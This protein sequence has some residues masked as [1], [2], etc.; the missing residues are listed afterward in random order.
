[1]DMPY[2]ALGLGM[3][4]SVRADVEPAWRDD[5]ARRSETFP[6]W[7]IVCYTYPGTAW[8][9]GATIDITWSDGSKYP[10]GELTGRMDG[11]DYPQ[12][13]ALLLGEKGVM[14]LPHGGGPQFFPGEKL[15]SLPRPKPEAWNHYHQ[16]IDAI[17]GKDGAVLQASFDYAGPLTEMVLLGTVALRFP[18]RSLTWDAPNL[19]VTNEAAA[20]RFVRRAYREGWEVEGL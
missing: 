5:P 11:R 9:A 3:P 4:L 15:R 13:G 18:G 2:R 7:Q 20:R 6:T 1:M 10:P 19:E 17:R 16:F 8:T 12:Q 14:L